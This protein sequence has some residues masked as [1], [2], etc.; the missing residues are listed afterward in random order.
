VNLIGIL[1]WWDESPAW[2]STAVAGFGRFCDTI[3]A[4]DGA[5]ALY[6]GGRAH[7]MP[8]QREAILAAAEAAGAGCIVHQPKDVWIGNEVEKRNH[9]LNLARAIGTENE[10]WVVI[11]D[12]DYQMMQTDPETVRARLADTHLNVATYT[13]LDGKDLL[14][15]TPELAQQ[16]DLSTEWAVRTR[17]IFR[18]LP[19]LRYETKHWH[20]VGD[21]PDGWKLTLFGDFNKEEPALQL[22]AALVVYHRRQARAKV[23]N[24]AAEGYY[25]LRDELGAESDARVEAEEVAA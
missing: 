19:N 22:E 10:D 23:R 21:D 9:T 8:D 7:S 18:L 12:G 20:V 14:A 2:L 15:E 1:S 17:G 11:F 5:Y 24:Q 13:M 25:Q 3:I 6:P 4:C 16:V